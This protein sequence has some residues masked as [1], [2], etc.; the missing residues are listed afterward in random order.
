ML[1][2][3]DFSKFGSQ[4]DVLSRIGD[5]DGDPIDGPIQLRWIGREFIAAITPEKEVAFVGSTGRVQ[6]LFRNG[7][8]IE[9]AK[10][11]AARA[12]TAPVV[13]TEAEVHYDN[14]FEDPH[15]LL[16]MEE[17]RAKAEREAER[18][19]RAEEAPLPAKRVTLQIASKNICRVPEADGSMRVAIIDEHNTTVKVVGKETGDTWEEVDSIGG[20]HIVV[21]STGALKPGMFDRPAGIDSLRIDGKILFFTCDEGN[22]TLQVVRADGTVMASVKGEGPGNYQFRNPT[23]LSVHLVPHGVR[24][25]D[26]HQEEMERNA[27]I[28]AARAQRMLEDQER[29]LELRG[30]KKHKKRPQT[31]SLGKV[32]KEDVSTFESSTGHD[33]KDVLEAFDEEKLMKEAAAASD[34]STLVAGVEDGTVDPSDY[35]PEWYLGFADHADLISHL[36]TNKR[37]G[38]PGDFAV[39][40]RIDDPNTYDLYYLAKDGEGMNRKKNSVVKLVL[41]R[42]EEDEEEDQEA[43][44]FLSTAVQQ[45]SKKLYPSIWDFIRTRGREMNQAGYDPRPFVNVAVADRNNYRVQIFKYFWTVIP[46]ESDLYAPSLDYFATVGGRLHAF[47]QLA[48]P[49]VVSYSPTG[50]LA[51][52]D[53]DK[54][55]KLYLISQYFSLIKKIDTPFSSSRV[56]KRRAGDD[57]PEVKNFLN[58]GKWPYWRP[59]TKTLVDKDG[60]AINDALINDTKD[61]RPQLAE[62]GRKKA[63]KNAK[64]MGNG[65]GTGLM[66]GAVSGSVY[67]PGSKHQAGGK[68]VEQAQKEAERQSREAVLPVSASFSPDGTYSVILVL[69]LSF[70]FA[71]SLCLCLDLLLL[72]CILSCHMTRV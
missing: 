18:I 41:Q 28:A 55:G 65:G 34:H 21:Q 58:G 44:I 35:I 3:R 9:A 53:E 29:E 43:G 57:E 20:K 38:K 13:D 49:S 4:Y 51:I 8:A 40:R 71:M 69:F 19:A 62:A 7:I 25:R 45:K 47:L 48:R 64:Y 63:E 32:T 6:T 39:G 1:S 24:I 22:N 11:A 67:V 15:Y 31:F 72:A 52:I 66:K 5:G 23:A 36:R 60:I 42:Q 56:R 26:G 59:A 12:G 17:K 68:T 37:S 14:W 10:A 16:T 54:G 61:D 27:K 2:G 70:L 50:E 30:G 46:A 33:H